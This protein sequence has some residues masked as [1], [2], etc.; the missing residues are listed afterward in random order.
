MKKKILFLLLIILFSVCQKSY[1]API[2]EITAESAIV[3][4]QNSGRILYSKDKDTQ[5]SMAS[6]TKIMTAIVAIENG[7]MDDLVTV[8]K[9]AAGIEGS[10]IWLEENE[11]IELGEL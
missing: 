9:E 3:I 5:R 2:P 8:S 4:E 6:T 11:K 10:S 7:N 1:A